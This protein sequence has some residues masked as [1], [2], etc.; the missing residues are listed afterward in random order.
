MQQKTRRK[1]N[2]ARLFF[3]CCL[4]EYT[5]RQTKNMRSDVVNALGKR[6]I[7]LIFDSSSGWY[8]L[9][10]IEQV[11]EEVVEECR[12]TEGN[13]D[14]VGDCRYPAPAYWE[15]GK[16]YQKLIRRVADVTKG[17]MI[18][19]LIR[20]YHSFISRKI[21]DYNSGAYLESTIYLLDCFLQN[22]MI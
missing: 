20:V 17:E 22:R 15:I 10:N 6:R 7:K 4:I 1:H 12:I 13:F 5:A 16:A 19:V 14:N 11:C 9:D 21:D 2:A 8:C 18:D 3:I